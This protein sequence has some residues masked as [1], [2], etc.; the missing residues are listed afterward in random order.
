VKKKRRRR[1]LRNEETFASKYEK[2]IKILGLD[3]FRVW[4]L[5]SLY[6][7][8]YS[9][10]EICFLLELNSSLGREHKRV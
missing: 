4:C 8:A 9:S 2:K 1:R 10:L 7:C 5:L 3:P 6:L